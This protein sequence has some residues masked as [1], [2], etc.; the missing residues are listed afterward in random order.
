MMFKEGR[1]GLLALAIVFSTLTA[2]PQIN[3]GQLVPPDQVPEYGTFYL[4]SVSDS[5]PLPIDSFPDCN[6]YS[7][8]NGIYAIDDRA[9]A[10]AREL[11]AAARA[12]EMQTMDDEDSPPGPDGGSGA[13]NDWTSTYDPHPYTSNDLW[14]ELTNIDFENHVATPRLHG[15]VEGDYYQ[16]LSQT[17]FARPLRDWN[18][19]E[20]VSG[21]S[22]QTDFS[23]VSID[24]PNLNFYRGHHANVIVGISRGWEAVE[25]DSVSGDAGQVGTF[26]ILTFENT[27]TNDITVLYSI[28]GTASNGVDYTNLTGVVTIPAGQGIAEVYIDPYEDN[29]P[30]G[31]ESVELRLIPTNTYLI[32]PE[33]SSA[34]NFI[35]DVSVTLSIFPQNDA[36]EP[37]GPTGEPAVQGSFLALRA[38][39]IRSHYPEL[40]V[41]YILTGVAKNGV[42]YTN[43]SGTFTFS[44]GSDREI[45]PFDALP[46]NLIEG[47]ESVIMTLIQTNG[48]VLDPEHTSATN[49]VLDSSTVIGV[50]ARSNAIETNIVSSI[51]G[52]VGCFELTRYDSRLDYSSALTVS[53]TVTGTASN[54]VDYTTIPITITFASGQTNTNIFIETI[55]DD[56]L[57]GD[58]TVILT[59]YATEDSYMISTDAPSA[60]LTIVDNVP[61]VPVVTNLVGPIGID[62]NAPSNSLLVSVEAGPHTYNFLRIYTNIVT[63]D[64]SVITN[65]IVTNWSEITDLPDEVKLATVKS[66]TDGFTNGDMF[67]GSNTGIGWVSSNGQAFNLDWCILTNQVVTNALNIRGSLY[68]DRTGTFSNQLIAV[69]SYGSSDPTSRKGVWRIDA[70]KNP[71]LLTNLLTPHLEGLITITNEIQRWGPWA[72]KILTGDEYK[73]DTNNIPT[74]LIFAIDTNGVTQTFDTTTLVPG[75]IFPED[76]DI[77]RTNQ[78]FYMCAVQ[79]NAILKLSASYLTNFVNDLLITDDGEVSGQ[80][81]LFI[82]HWNCGT[83][84]FDVRRI[85]YLRNDSSLPQLEHGTFAPIEL[86]KK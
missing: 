64:S 73:T 24:S 35:H 66:T 4:L 51:P 50:Y 86:P 71:T 67:F 81:C 23:Q 41:H 40:T 20:I 32:E 69:T 47:A 21:Q 17:N 78:S 3:S 42:D 33:S 74:P 28:S 27:P 6:V 37:D 60:T 15:T 75:G 29:L 5:A 54:G 79:Q 14:L 12:G 53:Y 8:S 52:K 45:I 38:D 72:G 19:G 22:D 16:L 57:E 62:Y 68:V 56:I 13:T 25:P 31:I 84:N 30:E 83:R 63:V 44:E 59:L 61:F 82:V 11:L 7:L 39:D 36:I 58:E 34:T 48:F 77:I 70:Q 55:S 49:Y 43:L 26:S 10:A 65:V 85:A 76:F 9:I 18:P 2:R 46:D 1:S 80:A